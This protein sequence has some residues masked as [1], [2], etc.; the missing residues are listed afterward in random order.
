M[1]KKVLT[2]LQNHIIHCRI[3]L[4]NAVRSVNC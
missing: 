2:V 1:Y 3:I 4:K